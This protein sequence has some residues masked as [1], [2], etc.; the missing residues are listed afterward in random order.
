MYFIESPH[1]EAN[2]DNQLSTPNTA[3]LPQNTNGVQNST[4]N[5]PSL[6]DAGISG[7]IQIKGDLKKLPFEIKR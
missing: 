6:P 1:V 7:T 2:I 5:M 3:N 4:A